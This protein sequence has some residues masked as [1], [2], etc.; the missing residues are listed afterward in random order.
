MNPVTFVTFI[1]DMLCH[2]IHSCVVVCE[3][4][5]IFFSV[6]NNCLLLND[7]D[8]GKV[9]QFPDGSTAIV[10]CKS[11]YIIFG[12][13]FIQCINGKWSSSLPKCIQY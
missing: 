3:T 2:H 5:N 1:N 4:V 13:S 7:P 11:G 12:Q 10:T 9:Y 6:G 8:N